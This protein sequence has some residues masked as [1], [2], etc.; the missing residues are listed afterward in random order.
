MTKLRV[1]LLTSLKAS[2]GGFLTS[3]S[4]VYPGG[5]EFIGT[6][7][8][9]PKDIARAVELEESFVSVTEIPIEEV[10]GG[11]LDLEEGK[12]PEVS[13]TSKSDAT[14]SAS[15]GADASKPSSEGETIPS[16]KPAVK[17]RIRR[18]VTSKPAKRKSVLKPKG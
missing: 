16:K 3:A 14:P 11:G 17:K 13:P 18:S 1:K 8:E 15:K 6:L 2:S 7:E 5:A 4:K 9:L 12:V 10:K